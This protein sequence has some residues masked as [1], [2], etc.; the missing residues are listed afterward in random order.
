MADVIDSTAE[1]T[2]PGPQRTGYS[3]LIAAVVGGVVGAVLVLLA[4]F[5]ILPGWVQ[6][7]IDRAIA[8][9]GPSPELEQRVAAVE[10]QNQQLPTLSKG[11]ADVSDQVK[12]VQS[13]L[14][15]QLKGAQSDLSSLQDKVAQA[16]DQAGRQDQ[17]VSGLKETQQKLGQQVTELQNRK[18]PDPVDLSP[19]QAKVEATQ[20]NMADLRSYAEQLT[21]R[22]DDVTSTNDSTVK[23]IDTLTS[24]QAG[25]ERRLNERTQQLSDRLAANDAA[26]S[27]KFADLTQLQETLTSMQSAVASQGSELSAAKAEIAATKS[28]IDDSE[29]K[30]AQSI[31]DVKDQV[32]TVE[33]Q[34]GDRL[35]ESRTGIATA[36]ALTDLERALEDGS[37]FP[38]AQAVLE[39][40]AK[41]DHAISQAASMLQ[42]SAPRGIATR[43]ELANELAALDQP[44]VTPSSKDWV[45]QTRANILGLVTVKRA[46]GASSSAGQT[47]G[48]ADTSDLALQKLSAGDL[49]GA[50]TV[51]SARPDADS[52]PVAQ[53]L[54]RAKA[55]ADAKAAAEMLRQHLG[56]LL[57]QPS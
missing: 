50:I 41:D 54:E 38:T 39:T 31:G 34:V 21:K 4:G 46:D 2:T 29:Q 30:S 9:I 3:R 55:R 40:A 18:I 15:D 37:A 23:R 14:S 26:I 5:L 33:K 16:A 28:A 25:T 22:V 48:S 1:E 35:Q 44:G 8:N 17:A 51:V 45:E 11:I 20:K 6:G 27:A 36:V 57:V 19:L 10:Q 7:K 24:A 49:A 32:A 43:A 53:W 12:S 52:K 13:S 42:E 47:G 56:E